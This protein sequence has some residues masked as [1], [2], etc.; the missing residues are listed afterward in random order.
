MGNSIKPNVKVILL[1]V[2]ILFPACRVLS[3]PP[4]IADEPLSLLSSTATLSST[5]TTTA[6]TSKK[7]Y[8]PTY[9]AKMTLLATA[10]TLTPIETPTPRSSPTRKPT[11]TSSPT[12]TPTLKPDFKPPAATFTPPPQ[13]ACP[14]PNLDVVFDEAIFNP[15]L[16][17][18]PDAGKELDYTHHN[19]VPFVPFEEVFIGF[20][21]VEMG[22]AEYLN[23]GG[24]LSQLQTMF[25]Q[26]EVS[27]EPR[28]YGELKQTDVTGDGVPEIFIWF[29][30]PLSP[31][32]PYPQELGYYNFFGKVIQ[33][34]RI[35][36]LTC[37]QNEY[38]PARDFE[39]EIPYYEI[40]V[41]PVIYDLDRDGVNEI[42][43]PVY[44][45][46][47]IRYSIDISISKWNGEHIS[48]LAIDEIY[49][50]HGISPFVEADT[51]GNVASLNGGDFELSDVDR[52]G[53]TEVLLID[54]YDWGGSCELLFR[55]TKL[56]LMWNGHGFSVYYQRTPPV[57]RIQ[58]V[59][60][61]DHMAIRGF[62]KEALAFFDQVINDNSLL[63]WSTDYKYVNLCSEEMAALPEDAV[64][65]KGERDRL[66][67]Y[68]LYR[69]MRIYTVMGE[70]ENAQTAYNRLALNYGD[71]SYAELGTVFWEAYQSSS[72][73]VQAQQAARTFS[74]SR[75]REVCT[76]L[77]DYYVDWIRNVYFPLEDVC[78]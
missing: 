15:I 70:L 51:W 45:L 77:T 1:V 22:V 44:S 11:L 9:Q 10:G 69:K 32:A 37:Q 26:Q 4:R 52:N 27:S 24:T 66:S 76:P 47:P 63:T 62:Y 21:Q 3:S 56:V 38:I 58:A 72:D 49:G 65:D 43:Q 71:S 40:W 30:L 75:K 64:L 36:I 60:D 2:L 42:I 5:S 18:F 19:N 78:P 7:D 29:A 31:E 25:D 46:S 48:K 55:E 50:D 35:F 53:T 61:G 67:A 34:T 74:I 17:L 41:M 13:A 57:Y 20:Q 59:W 12:V 14:P 16:E 8:L 73:L 39:M 68:A 6:T 33:Q 23:Q 54:G 28:Y